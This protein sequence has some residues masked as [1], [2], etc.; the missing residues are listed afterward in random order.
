LIAQKS[1]LSNFCRLVF[2]QPERFF[3]LERQFL[4][5][6]IPSGGTNQTCVKQ[7]SPSLARSFLFLLH[8]GIRTRLRQVRT[9]LSLLSGVPLQKPT[10]H[11]KHGKEEHTGENIG[12][13][14]LLQNNLFFSDLSSLRIAAGTGSPQKA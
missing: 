7:G 9:L 8:A 13:V 4:K 14:R 3:C 11:R 10:S 5:R 6:I 12:D 2:L 1:G